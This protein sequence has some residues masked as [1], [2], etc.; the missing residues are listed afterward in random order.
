MEATFTPAPWHY[1]QSTYKDDTVHHLV[2]HNRHGQ[3]MLVIC[4]IEKQNAHANAR[5]IAAAP[6]L[7]EALDDMLAI[8]GTIKSNDFSKRISQ[9]YDSALAVI[10]KARAA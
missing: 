10:A 8:V 1:M 5:L 6:E 2:G 9:R 4:E 7:L 3:T